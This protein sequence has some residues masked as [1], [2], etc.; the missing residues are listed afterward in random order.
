MRVPVILSDRWASRRRCFKFT[1]TRAVQHT[2]I[3]GCH[4]WSITQNPSNS[5]RLKW[6]RVKEPILNPLLIDVVVFLYLSL[7]HSPTTTYNAAYIYLHSFYLQINLHYYAC[8]C[9][10]FSPFKWPMFNGFIRIYLH[11]GWIFW[12]L[13]WRMNAPC[14]LFYYFKKQKK[15]CAIFFLFFCS[16]C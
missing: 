1:S 16:P 7:N 15:V 3:L 11:V 6:Q 9:C 10:S 4:R 2:S 13:F 5:K 14:I 8:R 12:R